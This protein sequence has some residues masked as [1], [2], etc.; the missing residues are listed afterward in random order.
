[1]VDV[2]NNE[3]QAISAS[4]NLRRVGLFG[5]FEVFFGLLEICFHLLE[6]LLDLLEVGVSQKVLDV[7]MDIFSELLNSENDLVVP[8]D[9]LN[10]FVVFFDFLFFKGFNFWGFGIKFGKKEGLF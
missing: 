5:L 1:L 2:V 6:V 3:F 9:L 10:F 4:P 8:K 7:H